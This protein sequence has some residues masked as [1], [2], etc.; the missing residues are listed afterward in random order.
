[1]V[2]EMK[3]K[4][5]LNILETKNIQKKFEESLKEVAKYYKKEYKKYKKFYAE[6]NFYDYFESFFY[7]LTC[8]YFLEK[9]NKKDILIPFIRPICDSRQKGKKIKHTKKNAWKKID[10]V[11]LKQIAGENK[12]L[13][14]ISAAEFKFEKGPVNLSHIHEKEIQYYEKYRNDLSKLAIEKKCDKYFIIIHSF[15]PKDEEK[16]RR[17]KKDQLKELMK[18]KLMNRKNY[19]DITVFYI[20]HEYSIICPKKKNYCHILR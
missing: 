20:T 17:E 7:M 16:Y 9:I 11:I 6:N 5:K 18:S 19:A 8:H 2:L 12:D 15:I 14:L 3:A 10:L 4:I 1:M 13:G